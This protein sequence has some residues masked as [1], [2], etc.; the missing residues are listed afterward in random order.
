MAILR[1]IFFGPPG[2][3]KGTQAKLLSREFSIPHISTGD[4]LRNAVARGTELGKKAKSIMET[5]GLVPDDV[6]TGIVKD[7]LSLPGASKGFILDG[8]PRTVPQAEA[9]ARLFGELGIDGFRVINFRVDEAEI[10]RRLSSRLVCEKDGAI[11]STLTDGVQRGGKCPKCGGKLIQR[12][13]DKE[14]TI[15]RRLSVYEST[16]RQ[17][18]DFYKSKPGVVVDIDAIGTIEEVHRE[19]KRLVET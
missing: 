15:L 2:V 12:E 5:G 9:L 6:I 10:T 13:D 7:E 17:L 1:L 19:I 4:M 3:G 8:F 16:T 11:F 18:I 14:E